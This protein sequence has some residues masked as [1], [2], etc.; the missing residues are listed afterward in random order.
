M[1]GL[2]G[3]IRHGTQ[4]PRFHLSGNFDRFLV[5]LFFQ[6]FFREFILKRAVFES[7]NQFAHL[8]HQIFTV[9]YCMPRFFGFF[10][11][12][13]EDLDSRL[14]AAGHVSSATYFS[15]MLEDKDR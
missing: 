8:N 15:N 7:L 14:G 10:I 2:G 3:W 9:I 12:I 6:P 4:L 5:N 11:Q 13:L 1:L